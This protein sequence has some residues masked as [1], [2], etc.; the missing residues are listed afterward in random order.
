MNKDKETMANNYAS[1]YRQD[2][3][4]QHKESYLAGF[5]AGQYC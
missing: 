1:R 5:D 2:Y 4:D 3:F